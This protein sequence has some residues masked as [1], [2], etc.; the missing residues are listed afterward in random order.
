MRFQPAVLLKLY[1]K[2]NGIG[3]EERL[4]LRKFIM[5]KKEQCNFSKYALVYG[6]LF[7]E[8][9]VKFSYVENI[10][11][12]IMKPYHV[13]E[14][15]G[16]TANEHQKEE[17]TKEE[18]DRWNKNKSWGLEPYN[19][20]NIGELSPDQT[21]I[22]I[23]PCSFRY[24][25]DRL[26][27]KNTFYYNRFNIIQYISAVIIGRAMPDNDAALNNNTSLNSIF[28]DL[29][30]LAFLSDYEKQQIK[31][32]VGK[33]IEKIYQKQVEPYNNKS[34][35]L[36]L[37]QKSLLVYPADGYVILGNNNTNRT[38]KWE[39]SRVYPRNDEKNVLYKVNTNND[40][41]LCIFCPHKSLCPQGLRYKKDDKD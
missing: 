12:E 27:N 3:Y 4:R 29:D 35:R 22:V 37:I 26:L 1:E 2:L 13:F 21:D 19:A 39:D 28:A 36:K 8:C 30:K 14:L 34:D 17:F 11:G 31:N 7:S 25:F 40:L 15:L 6:I 32:D 9:R 23:E 24:V 38:L 18:K 10:D 33:Q 41:D 5:A 16:M 20:D